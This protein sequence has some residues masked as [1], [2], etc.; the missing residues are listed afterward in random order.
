M[1]NDL[2]ARKVEKYKINDFII[3][4]CLRNDDNFSATFLKA[5]Q[6]NNEIIK[7]L[8]KVFHLTDNEILHLLE[9]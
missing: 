1:K 2:L 6:E 4:R 7:Y 9:D 5:R 3:E 8:K